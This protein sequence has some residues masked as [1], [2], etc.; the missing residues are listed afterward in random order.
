M[1]TYISYFFTI[2][3]MAFV[4]CKPDRTPVLTNVISGELDSLPVTEFVLT[5]SPSGA[6]PFI[7]TLTWT[8]SEFFLDGKE[9]PVGNINYLIEADQAGN[10]FANP[11]V[12][13]A[14][15]AGN[16]LAANF[17][18][19]D[20][21]NILLNNFAAMAGQKINLDLRLRT[22]YGE[23]GEDNYV[24]SKESIRVS[25][26]AFRPENELIPHYLIGDMTGWDLSARTFLMYRKDNEITNHVH[27]YTG[28]F[29]ANTRFRFCAELAFGDTNKMWGKGE[30]NS[31]VYGGEDFVIVTEGYYTLT[32]D[33]K[34]KTYEIVPFDTIG[35]PEVSVVKIFGGFNGWE[36]GSAPEMQKISAHNWYLDVEMSNIGSGSK[37]LVDGTDWG[38]IKTTDIPYG[39]AIESG[40]NNLDLAQYGDG[41][42]EVRFNDLTGHYFVKKID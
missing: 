25:F 31:M 4:S 39:I 38:P 18:V 22:N 28:K 27:T 2:L 9:F 5:E 29:G 12:F 7:M 26:V 23:N 10:N 41:T 37:F 33:D 16:P 24:V 19:N 21:N 30:G 1:K 3:L 42:Y 36:R 13:A 20:V 8:K 14:S 34:A 6:N 17:Y 15:D 35:K 11:V 32:I 40:P